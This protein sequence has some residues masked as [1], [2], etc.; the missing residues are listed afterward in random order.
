MDQISLGCQEVNGMSPVSTRK[1]VLVV[2]DSQLFRS[3]LHGML[4]DEYDVLE[5]ED[6]EQALE[7]LKTHGKAVLAVVL[8][9]VM[10]KM[11]GYEFLEHIRRD[12]EYDNLP[13]IMATSCTDEV[14]EIRALQSGAWDFITKP[15]NKDI[16]LL[17][18]KH[19]IQRSELYSLEQ[20]KYMAEYDIVTGIYNKET[21]FRATERMVQQHREHDFALVRFDVNRFQ[22]INAF[23]GRKE[24]D[25]LLKYIGSCI[26]DLV[27]SFNAGTYGHIEADIFCFCAPAELVISNDF[28]DLARKRLAAYNL[29]YDIVPTFGVF[30]IKDPMMSLDLMFDCA[31]LAAKSCKGNY[32]DFYAVYDERMR[33]EL[34]HEQEIINEMKSALDQQQFDIYLQPKYDLQTDRE[35]GAEA[36]VRWIHPSK[37]I[38]PPGDFIPVFEQNGFIMKLDYYV[39][40]RVCQLLRRWKE[41]GKALIPISVNVSRVNLYNPRLCDVLIE[42]V[43]KYDIDPAYLNLELTESAYM[44]NPSMM[45]EAMD[46]LQKHGFI[47]MMDDFGSGYSSLNILKDI[48]V[49]VL[50]IDM[51]FLS[52]CVVKGRGEN[53]LTS[54]IRMAKWLN[55]PVIV[56]GVETEPQADFLRSIGCDQAQGFYFARPMPVSMYEAH[57]DTIHTSEIHNRQGLNKLEINDF[58]MPNVQVNLLFNSILSAVGLYEMNGDRLEIIRANDQ[59]FKVTGEKR[60]DFFRIS[61]DIVSVVVDED[62]DVVRNAFLKASTTSAAQECRYRR[63][64]SDGSVKLIQMRIQHIL[65]AGDRHLFYGSFNDITKLQHSEGESHLYQESLLLLE[66]ILSTM[67]EDSYKERFDE[68]KGME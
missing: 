13:V 17:R 9:L 52:T 21:F 23:F 28:F 57:L 4:K 7:V 22:L 42:L 36:L 45:R 18:L 3:V 51:R 27:K 10:P 30:P 56:E 26:R 47:I 12:Y 31:N 16:L 41:E 29:S 48:A 2:E 59:F 43:E 33:E 20:M 19:L 35:S 60:E 61:S 32:V 44:D 54:V 65:T 14:S 66:E 63:K 15:Y 62:Q 40:E 49:D 39:W 34:I 24:G 25:R 50:K 46:R 37:G 11:D 6:G 8:N 58:W 5:A 38:I 68:L 64:C 55:I 1:Y 67:P 53:I